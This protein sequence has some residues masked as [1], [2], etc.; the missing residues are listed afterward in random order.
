MDEL[1]QCPFC[2]ASAF[3]WEVEESSN[4]SFYFPKWYIECGR[5]GIKTSTGNKDTVVKIWNRR[6]GAEREEG[7]E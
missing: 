2:G 6:E 3:M 7:E 4:T 1:K 5:C